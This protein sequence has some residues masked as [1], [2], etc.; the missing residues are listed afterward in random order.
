MSARACLL[1]AAARLL[2]AAAGCAGRP[3][4]HI[5]AVEGM[6]VGQAGRSLKA[7]GYR[8][9]QVAPELSG[10]ETTHVVAAYV[11]ES[12]RMGGDGRDVVLLVGTMDGENMKTP[13]VSGFGLGDAKETLRSWGLGLGSLKTRF[14]ST[15]NSGTVVAQDPTAGVVVKRGTAVNLVLSTESR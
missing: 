14:D 12:S 7:A 1:V 4:P 5:R 3:D 13:A 6:S 15:L 9:I 11:P 8:V 10:R 2:L